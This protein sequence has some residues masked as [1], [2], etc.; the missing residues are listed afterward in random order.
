MITLL[1]QPTVALLVA[2]D[3]ASFQN[4]VKTGQNPRIRRAA[5]PAGD[6]RTQQ[7]GTILS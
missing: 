3:K 1:M 5:G 2:H 7:L 4:Q 6:C